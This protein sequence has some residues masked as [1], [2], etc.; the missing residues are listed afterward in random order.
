MFGTEM[1]GWEIPLLISRK[2]D[3][4]L[5]GEKLKKKGEAKVFG[6]L[7]MRIL[8]SLSVNIIEKSD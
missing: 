2:K 8:K 5:W 1:V 4:I 6:R 3:K 7:F